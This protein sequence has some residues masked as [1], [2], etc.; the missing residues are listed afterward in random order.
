MFSAS[1]SCFIPGEVMTDWTRSNRACKMRKEEDFKFLSSYSFSI[2]GQSIRRYITHGEKKAGEEI[3]QSIWLQC[4]SSIDL[5]SSPPP[6]PHLYPK[7]SPSSCPPPPPSPVRFHFFLS[8]LL[9]SPSPLAHI[10]CL[11][12]L[13]SRLTTSS[14]T[15]ISS[16]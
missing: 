2:S 6:L 8:L 7:T 3:S 9:Q 14:S 10:A 5:S 1:S 13:F 11:S 15:S 16:P 12:L 4:L